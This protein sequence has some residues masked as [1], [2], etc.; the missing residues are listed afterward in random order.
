MNKDSPREPAPQKCSND[1]WYA[2]RFSEYFL[3]ILLV[4]AFVAFLRVIHIFLLLIVV[5]AVFATLFYPLYRWLQRRIHRPGWSALACILILFVGFLI[6]V[7][8]VANLVADQA[9]ELYQ[10]AEPRI[11]A[12]LHKGNEGIPGKL[13][14]TELF[15][16]ISAFNIDWQSSL[17]QGMRMMGT[18]TAKLINKTSLATFNFVIDVLVLFY[19]MFYFFRDGEEITR[20]IAYVIPMNAE[21]KK[22]MIARFVAIARATV[23]S[24][25]VIGLIQG[26]VGAV[27]LA[28]FGVSTWLLWGVV[29]GLLS[30]IPVVGAWTVLVPAG[31]IMIIDGRVWQGL[32]L[33][34]VSTVVLSMID[35]I[36]RPILV[37]RGA[38]MHDLLTFCS[39]L[40]GLSLF[41]V[42]GFV[43]GPMIA[44]LFLTVVDI[45]SVEFEGNLE[46]PPAAGEGER[47]QPADR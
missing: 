7:V 9:V 38:R 1:R 20:R 13:R 28:S 32:V 41:G 40:G 42:M 43:I 35:N 23:K 45:Y 4:I 33:I 3:L 31:I 34:V 14:N 8:L 18:V 19:I 5:A 21:Y 25:L 2:G 22:R 29:M 39:T 24:T 11:I 30:I 12:L 44:A 27:L 46:K 37:G 6:P 17:S 36:V 26:T 15:R 47:G 16:W 10:T